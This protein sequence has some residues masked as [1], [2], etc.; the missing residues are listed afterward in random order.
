[1]LKVISLCHVRCFIVKLV[2]VDVSRRITLA[3]C[4]PLNKDK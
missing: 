3:P 4:H 2:S 1:V